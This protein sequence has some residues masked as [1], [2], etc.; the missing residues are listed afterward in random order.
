[1]LSGG[2]G[3]GESYPYRIL[4]APNNEVYLIFTIVLK[5]IRTGMLNK[6]LGLYILK[7]ERSK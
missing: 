3:K 6:G 5:V 2:L 1:M 4:P 7:I